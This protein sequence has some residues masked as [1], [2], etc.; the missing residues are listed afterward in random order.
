MVR[1]LFGPH[2]LESCGQDFEKKS[3]QVAINPKYDEYQ[4]GL[5]SVVYKV[6]DKKTGLAATRRSRA[7]V[8]EELRQ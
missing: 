7:S 5:A 2:F 1:Q 8:N 6:F 4:Q 3:L